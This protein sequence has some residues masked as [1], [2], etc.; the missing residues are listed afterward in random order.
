[1]PLCLI[2]VYS[3]GWTGFAEIVPDLPRIDAVSGVTRNEGRSVTESHYKVSS[4]FVS[5]S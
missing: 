2:Y 5:G 1:M 4:V 3:K